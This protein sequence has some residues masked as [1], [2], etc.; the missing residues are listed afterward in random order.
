MCVSSDFFL[1]I[2]STKQDF[3]VIVNGVLTENCFKNFDVKVF[4]DG[5]GVYDWNIDTV[6]LSIDQLKSFN[7]SAIT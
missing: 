4:L 5:S 6:L 7:T 3:S 1:F 2:F